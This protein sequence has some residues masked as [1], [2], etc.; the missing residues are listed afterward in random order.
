MPAN[1]AAED[2]AAATKRSVMSC[3]EENITVPET[4]T[5]VRGSATET[6]ARP[7]RRRLAVGS[8]LSAR[9]ATTPVASVAAAT[10]RAKAI[11]G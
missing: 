5:A 9:A 3:P 6:R 10:I 4:E 7:A 11:T 8:N 1:T 2:E